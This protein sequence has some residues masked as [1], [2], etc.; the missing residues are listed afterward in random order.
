[1]KKKKELEFVIFLVLFHQLILKKLVDYFFRVIFDV[2][3]LT[4]EIHLHVDSVLKRTIF[5]F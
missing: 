5:F 1:M 4:F 2:F 3:Q